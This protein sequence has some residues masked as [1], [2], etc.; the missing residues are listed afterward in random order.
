MKPEL[1]FEN[2]LLVAKAVTGVDTD[3]DGEMA[4]KAE[5]VIT[6]D[7]KEAVAEIVKSGVPQWLKDLIAK[8]A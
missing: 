8:V 4:I 7:A 5:V 6:I 1:K 2:G 3:K